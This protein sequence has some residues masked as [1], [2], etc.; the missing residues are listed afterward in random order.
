VHPTRRREQGGVGPERDADHLGP[1]VEDR[2][3]VLDQ[4]SD[5]RLVAR[6]RERLARE[7]RLDRRVV[8]AMPVSCFSTSL[9][10]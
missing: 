1:S 4:G 9:A 10:D 8:T 7:Q 3:R 2:G 5:D 6:G